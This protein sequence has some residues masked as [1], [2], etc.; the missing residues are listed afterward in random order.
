MNR[1]L[2]PSSNAEKSYLCDQGQSSSSIR[3]LGVVAPL[4]GQVLPRSQQYEAGDCHD[5]KDV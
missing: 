2:C 1:Y 3:T 5:E 4:L